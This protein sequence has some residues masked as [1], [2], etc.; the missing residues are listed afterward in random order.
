MTGSRAERSLLGAILLDPSQARAVHG[1]VSG[2]DFE[3]QRLG[4]IFARMLERAAAGSPVP[5]GTVSTN[6]PEWGIRGIE[7]GAEFDWI[8]AEM[9]VAYAAGE[10][11]RTV[12]TDA[13]RRALGTVNSTISG[14]LQQ[15]RSPSD[16]ATSVLSQLTKVIEGGSSG[17]MLTKTLREVMEGGTDEYDWVI[18]NLLERRDRLILTG[19]EGLGKTTLSRQLV[20]LAAAGIHPITF[21]PMTPARVL[22]VDAEN[23]EVQWR[24]EVKWIIDG[25]KHHGVRDPQDFIQIKA[26]SRID[27]TSGPDLADI[28][29]LVDA[30]KPDLLYIGPL[31]KLVQ[32]AITND[33]DAAPLIVALDSLR[34]RGLAL[35]MEAHAG[36]AA[37]ANGDRDLRPRGS[38]ALLGW[39]EFGLGLKPSHIGKPGQAVDVV[40]WRGGR[41]RDRPWPKTLWRGST[42]PWEASK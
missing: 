27:I 24:R 34:D 7:A 26:G 12:R 15:G 32:G 2:T 4:I 3:D 36:K 19:A 22:V 5:I 31:Y 13:M 29:R 16:V 42:W 30:Q 37:G 17:R 8:D 9:T 25:A 11:A 14:Q 35:V 38:A 28:H 10:Y 18:P 23:T 41:D 39:P 21:A 20:I 33:D 40:P 6:F 1:M